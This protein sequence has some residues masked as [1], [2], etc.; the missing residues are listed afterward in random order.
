M[1]TI[2]RKAAFLRALKYLSKEAGANISIYVIWVK[3]EVHATMH[4][5]YRR[6]LLISCRLLLV[7]RSRQHH[8]E[9]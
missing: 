2:A 3:R 7:P 4:T 8:E 6:L 9:F 5:F 1:R